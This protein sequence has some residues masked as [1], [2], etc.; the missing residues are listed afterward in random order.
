MMVLVTGALGSIG[1]E[2]VRRLVAGGN[3]VIALDNNSCPSYMEGELPGYVEGMVEFWN[4]SV[5][6]LLVDYPFPPFDAV[7]HA[8]GIVGPASVLDF[9]IAKNKYVQPIAVQTMN[10]LYAVMR[11]ST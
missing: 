4:A 7:V 6:S 1:F 8:A 3:H 9:K 2:I 5:S 10:D 11:F